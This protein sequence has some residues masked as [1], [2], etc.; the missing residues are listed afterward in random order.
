MHTT[1]PTGCRGGPR[2]AGTGRAAATGVGNRALAAVSG[3]AIASAATFSRVA[4]PEMRR[5]GYKKGYALGVITGSACLGMLIP[6]SVLLIV[7]AILTEGSV[8]ALFI[9]GIGPGLILGLTFIAY[10]VIAAIRDPSIAPSTDQSHD[11]KLDSQDVRSQLLGGL[12]VVGLIAL[13]LGGLWGGL[14]TPTEGAGVGVRGRL[15]IG[16]VMVTPPGPSPRASADPG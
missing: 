11:A 5:L 2:H 15:V 10:C 16:L 13:V 8:G 14:F 9:G 12:G 4:Y 3:V 6:P 7:W 1:T